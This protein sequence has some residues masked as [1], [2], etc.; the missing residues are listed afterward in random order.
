MI[1]GRNVRK[2]GTS[3]QRSQS[4]VLHA[5]GGRGGIPTATCLQNF[6]NV[7][8]GSGHRVAGLASAS[9]QC[10]VVCAPSHMLDTTNRGKCA[11]RGLAIH[12]PAG[13][14]TGREFAPGRIP[15]TGRRPVW[16]VTQ[17]ADGQGRRVAGTECACPRSRTPCTMSRERVR[18]LPH[19][20]DGRLHRKNGIAHACRYKRYPATCRLDDRQRLAGGPTRPGAAVSFHDPAARNA[21]TSFLH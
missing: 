3:V 13:S 21:G 18:H 9:R 6:C 1:S 12:D 19:A 10:S 17:R 14:E 15:G 5:I 8:T 4:L 2:L 11:D 16:P 7:R 20:T